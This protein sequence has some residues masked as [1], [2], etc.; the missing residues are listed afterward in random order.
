MLPLEIMA[1][2]RIQEIGL[3]EG[4]ALYCRRTSR[5]KYGDW[6]MISPPLTVNEAEIEELLARLRKTLEVFVAELVAKKV[7]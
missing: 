4:I 6:L 2:N 7:I 1:P 5:G 3:A